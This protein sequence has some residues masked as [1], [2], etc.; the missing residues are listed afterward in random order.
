V[1]QRV[2]IMN[3]FGELWQERGVRCGA[4]LVL[5]RTVDGWSITHEGSGLAIISRLGRSGRDV[6]DRVRAVLNEVRPLADWT[7]NRDTLFRNDDLRAAIMRIRE[8]L[9]GEGPESLYR[10][11]GP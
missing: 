11:S 5:A 7:L 3:A 2:T 9:H 8:R 1:I 4:G 10:L 6:S